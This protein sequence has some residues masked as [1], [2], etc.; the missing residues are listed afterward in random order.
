MEFQCVKHMKKY[1]ELTLEQIQALKCAGLLL[2]IY[3]ESANQRDEITFRHEIYP[4]CNS[5]IPY[6]NPIFFAEFTTQDGKDWTYKI[7]KRNFIVSEAEYND[8]LT[9]VYDVEF[10]PVFWHGSIEGHPYTLH[11]G[12]LNKNENAIDLE[13]KSFLKYTVDAL[14]AYKK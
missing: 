10:V 2:E 6:H 7:C 14:N 9:R 4:P 8:R 3:P 5:K 1:S 11:E 12:K 13:T